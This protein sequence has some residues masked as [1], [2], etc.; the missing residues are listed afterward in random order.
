MKKILIVLSVL[1]I[2]LIIPPV[3]K[4]NDRTNLVGPVLSD[5]NFSEVTF[6]NE[7]EN[8]DLGGMIF[9]PEG[10][11]PYPVAESRNRIRENKLDQFVVKVYPD[12]GHGILERTSGKVNPAFLDDLTRFITASCKYKTEIIHDH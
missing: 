2:I 10:P 8:F 12:G 11:G 9:R 7:T 6:K 1:I 4:K 5:L 3:F